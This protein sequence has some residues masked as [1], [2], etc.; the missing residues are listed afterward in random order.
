MHAEYLG[1]CVEH[2]PGW[3]APPTSGLLIIFVVVVVVLRF[4]VTVHK[5][6]HINTFVANPESLKRL[7]SAIASQ[8][9]DR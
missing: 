7:P 1:A 8:A 3:Q 2:C 4:T 5:L 6:S 9:I